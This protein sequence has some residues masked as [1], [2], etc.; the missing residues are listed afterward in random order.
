MLIFSLMSICNSISIF[1]FLDVCIRIF[2][3]FQNS[4]LPSKICDSLIATYY[5]PEILNLVTNPFPSET[6]NEDVIFSGENISIFATVLRDSFVRFFVSFG[7]LFLVAFSCSFGGALHFYYLKVIDPK[8]LLT[9]REPNGNF[10]C[11]SL[12]LVALLICASKFGK[13]AANTLCLSGVML[14]LYLIVFMLAETWQRAY[15]N[16]SVRDV[17]SGVK[18]Y[19]MLWLVGSILLFF[20]FD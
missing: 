3:E 15:R 4:K 8:K 1:N 13:Y 18:S 9:V 12:L 19:M 5:T 17:A 10:F 11:S 14:R 16:Q 6:P 2:I 20:A 7:W